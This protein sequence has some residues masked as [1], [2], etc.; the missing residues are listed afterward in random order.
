M[1]VS[2]CPVCKAPVVWATT[3][4]GKKQRIDEKPADAGTIELIAMGDGEMRCDVVPKDQRAARAG[5]LHL[6]H[7]ATC[8]PALARRRRERRR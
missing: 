3:I 2:R 7:A 4:H 8:A 5:R 1:I 6:P